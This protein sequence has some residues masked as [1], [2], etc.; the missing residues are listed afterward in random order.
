[1]KKLT[2]IFLVLLILLVGFVQGQGTCQL[3]K[4]QYYK[5]ETATLNCF[6][7]TPQEKNKS[8]IEELQ[9]EDLDKIAGGF[10]PLYQNDKVG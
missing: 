2:I 9:K 5:G 8:E 7:D 1:M 4:Y 10:I 6:C 3:D